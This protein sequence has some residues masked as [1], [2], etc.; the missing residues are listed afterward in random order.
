MGLRLGGVGSRFDVSAV[1]PAETAAVVA[2]ENATLGSLL[3]EVELVLFLRA[4]TTCVV[5][6][7]S[8]CR[9]FESVLSP[10]CC[11]RGSCVG[12]MYVLFLKA[13]LKS[14]VR[15]ILGI[16]DK[17]SEANLLFPFLCADQVAARA[18]AVLQTQR[19]AAVDEYSLSC[20]TIA[21]ISHACSRIV[22]YCSAD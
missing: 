2:S 22:S 1:L 20:V 11:A 13:L 4:G 5:S 14:T 19:R 6:S 9:A 21:C 3:V 8:I 10:K 18:G 7:P 16:L 12:F 15:L 17:S